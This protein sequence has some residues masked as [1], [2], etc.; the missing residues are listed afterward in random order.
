M[1]LFKKS[2]YEKLFQKS[3]SDIAEYYKQI[4]DAQAKIEEIKAKC[5]HNLFEVHMYMWRPG[6]MQPQRICTSCSA[7]IPG[8]TQEETDKAWQEWHQIIQGKGDKNAL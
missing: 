4:S 1:K 7:V 3:E 6:A 2:F 8:V 5:P